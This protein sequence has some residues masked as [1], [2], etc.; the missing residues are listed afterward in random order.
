MDQNRKPRPAGAA[1]RVPALSVI[2]GGLAE[3]RASDATVIPVRLRDGGCSEISRAIDLLNDLASV[4]A[5]M[6]RSAREGRRICLRDAR[7]VVAVLI[8]DF[9]ADQNALHWALAANTR[10]YHL[11]RRAVGCAVL[12]LA[13]GC[14]LRFDCD[15]LRDLV[16]GALLLDI[17]KLR[18]PVVIL[19]K[20]GRLN[21]AENRFA[22][23]HVSAGVRLVEVIDGIPADAVEMVR[24]HHERI[25]GSGFPCRLRGDEISLYAQIAGIIDSYDAM[26]VSRYYAAG[27]SGAAALRELRAGAGTKFAPRLVEAFAAAIGELPT[28]TWVEFPDGCLGVVGAQNAA[29]ETGARVALIADEQQQPFLSV[30][31][32]SLEKRTDVRVLPPAERPLQSG[33]MERSL[34]S[35]IYAF[36]PRRY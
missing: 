25:D 34:Q 23:R 16:L 31:W 35:A 33:A 29:D 20:L 27:Q 18:I 24:S 2:D 12:A 5:A 8:D 13:L 3:Q 4:V 32:L 15:E 26:T 1:E 30:R 36:T 17:G 14:Q 19:A 11:C 10:M 9:A 28:G 7:A 6:H 21:D 22:R